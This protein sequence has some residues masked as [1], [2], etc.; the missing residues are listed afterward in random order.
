MTASEVISKHV[1]R[2]SSKSRPS[3]VCYMVCGVPGSGKSTFI[4]TLLKDRQHHHEMLSFENICSLLN[5]YRDAELAFSV[6]EKIFNRYVAA[7]VSF[8]MELDVDF[9]SETTN[10]EIFKKFLLCL[11][12]YRRIFVFVQL[13]LE[14][15][16]KRIEKRQ[17]RNDLS[18]D[19]ILEKQNTLKQIFATFV[20][21]FHDWYVYYGSSKGRKSFRLLYSKKDRKLI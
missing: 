12:P 5:N 10:L 21:H 19:F 7:S 16:K 2:L 11:K 1:N 3:P 20:A 8:V 18:L 14:K 9:G 17:F 13:D 15:A 4:E 6:Y